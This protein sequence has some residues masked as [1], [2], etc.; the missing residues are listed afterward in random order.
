LDLFSWRPDDDIIRSKH[1]ALTSILFYGIKNKSV[2]LL[3][4][5]LFL[6]VVTLRKG[7]LQKKKL[8]V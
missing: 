2:V 7:K 3:T 5:V 8:N 4:D 6:C 1:V